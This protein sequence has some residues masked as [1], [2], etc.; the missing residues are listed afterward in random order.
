MHRVLVTGFEPFGGDRL[1]PSALVACEL[2]GRMPVEGG[3]LSVRS[4]VLPCTFEGAAKRLRVA[5]QVHEPSLVVCL[6]LASGRP[7]LGFERVA[8]NLV[9][10]RIADNRGQQPL[11]QRVLPT[12]RD[13]Y[14]STLPVKA[15]AQAAR[16]AG[17]AAEVSLSAGSFVCNAVF[18]ALMHELHQAVGRKA[19][20]QAI[21]VRGG[22]VHLPNLPMQVRGKKP[23]VPSMPLRTMVRGVKAALVTAAGSTRDVTTV[24]GRV[25]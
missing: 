5:L 7:A 13:A 25:A 9:D 11:D 2:R 17:A 22:F 19:S 14:F 10:A 21:T 4:V 12:L 3:W 20:K 23:A 6:G 15:M 18:F 1:N 24:E 16:D 8:I